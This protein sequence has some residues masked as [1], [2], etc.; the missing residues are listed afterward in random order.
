M[1]QHFTGNLTNFSFEGRASRAEYWSFMLFWVLTALVL[2]GSS[3]VLGEKVGSILYAAFVVLTIVQSL[4]LAARRMHD[5][6]K[7][8]WFVLTSAIPFVGGLI[9]LVLSVLPG[10]QGPNNYGQDPYGSSKATSVQGTSR[11]SGNKG[12]WK[13]VA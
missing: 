11:V 1:L 7:S 12:G 2:G 13:K 6:D 5:I 3:L 10:T 8:G 9:Y 4:A